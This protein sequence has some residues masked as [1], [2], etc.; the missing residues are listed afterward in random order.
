M[1][2]RIYVGNLPSNATEK[3]LR[4]MF[5]E[6]GTVKEV[7]LVNDRRTG[8]RRGYVEMSKGGDKAIQAL[9]Q[10]QMGGRALEVSESRPRTE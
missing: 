10:R 7:N 3:D 5:G 1:A 4:Q 6:F 8:R 2:K 9:H